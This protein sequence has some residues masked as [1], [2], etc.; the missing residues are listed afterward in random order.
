MMAGYIYTYALLEEIDDLR[1]QIARLQA[2]LDE[3]ERERHA[4]VVALIEINEVS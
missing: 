2:K 1:R 4:A 3:Y